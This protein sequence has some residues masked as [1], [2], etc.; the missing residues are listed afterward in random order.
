MQD[1]TWD[2]I[3]IGSGMGGLTAAALLTKFTRKKVLVL[4]RHTKIGGCTHSFSRRK[5]YDFDVGVHFLGGLNDG[6]PLYRILDEL[7][8][9]R[10]KYKRLS[11]DLEYLFMPDGEYR[12]PVEPLPLQ[13]YLEREFPEERE[14]LRRYFKMIEPLGRAFYRWQNAEVHPWP[15]PYLIRFWLKL[16]RRR[17]FLTTQV[18]LD[19][20]FKSDRLKT[21][22]TCQWPALG[23]MP[24][25]GSFG[26]HCAN[27]AWAKRGSFYPEGGGERLPEELARTIRENGG[28]ILTGETVERILVKN[29]RA[30]GVRLVA[31]AEHGSRDLFSQGVISCAGARATYLDLLRDTPISFREEIE[32]VDQKQGFVGI[33][34]GVDRSPHALGIGSAN[35][36]IFH[37]DRL[38]SFPSDEDLNF[39]RG[40]YVSSPSIKR[41][42]QA[43]T[44]E[45]LML[46]PTDFFEKRWRNS[47]WRRR[48]E[49]YKEFKKK[50]YEH[51]MNLLEPHFPGLRASVLFHEVSTPLSVQHFITGAN[52]SI[53]IPSTP[54]RFH[55]KW[56][57]SR[58]PIKG[59][60]LAGSDTVSW[61][62]AGAVFGGIKAY[63]LFKKFEGKRSQLVNDLFKRNSKTFE[64]GLPGLGLSDPDHHHDASRS[65]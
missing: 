37:D 29:G 30:V 50:I 8:Q 56:T 32:A 26:I 5:D 3:I 62:V 34:L 16:S 59:L 33:Y 25:L 60:Y 15:L 61:S 22:L 21:L 2:A 65:L 39:I 17:L 31:N 53:G 6:S 1:E 46:S 19:R 38:G 48:P 64:R 52:G 13:V 14:G 58:T 44:I 28:K 7:S 27:A 4:E 45:I 55:F 35:Y 40:I 47:S 41:G 51:V 24:E 49:D 57:R 42:K 9:G 10:L 63:R 23:V 18:A 11:E 12:L 20:L 36:W 54:A 43:H